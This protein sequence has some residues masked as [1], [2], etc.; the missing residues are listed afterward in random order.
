MAYRLVTMNFNNLHVWFVASKSL[1]LQNSTVLISCF[2][3]R[4][5]WKSKYF[6]S[7][8]ALK[9]ISGITWP[10]NIQFLKTTEKAHKQ[11]GLHD[12][13][14]TC[15]CI[16]N[17][18]LVYSCSRYARQNAAPSNLPPPLQTTVTVCTD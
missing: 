7:S 15:T 8:T 10:T 9:L 4:L 6:A 17:I 16:R 13:E 2:N 1:G 14:G 18:A 12:K 3:H 5:I 11:R